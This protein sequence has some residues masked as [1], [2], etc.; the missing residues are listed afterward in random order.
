MTLSGSHLH[1]CT[2]GNALLGSFSV[3]LV[4]SLPMLFCKSPLIQNTCLLFVFT[5]CFS[6]FH[7]LLITPVVLSWVGLRKVKIESPAPIRREDDHRSRTA[8]SDTLYSYSDPDEYEV[9]A[10]EGNGVADHHDVKIISGT[11]QEDQFPVSVGSI[12]PSLGCA[13][14]SLPTPTTSANPSTPAR[15]P[16]GYKMCFYY[17]RD[18]M[19]DFFPYYTGEV[20]GLDLSM[21]L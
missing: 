8:T 13:S 10:H 9:G 21:R 19:T 14:F 11:Q 20:I 5:M 6:I 16:I 18:S 17:H 4:G 12:S 1:D 2:T 7:S 3:R 15:I